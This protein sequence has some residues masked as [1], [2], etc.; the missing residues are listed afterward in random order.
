MVTWATS[1]SQG[2]RLAFYSIEVDDQVYGALSH[3]DIMRVSNQG[4]QGW[5][6]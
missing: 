1:G 6:Y 5:L 4:Q 2:D 3:G